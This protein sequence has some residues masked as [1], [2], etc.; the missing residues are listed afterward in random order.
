MYFPLTTAS[1]LFWL[2]K[3]QVSFNFA[4]MARIRGPFTPVDLSTALHRAAERHPLA[5][6]R[7]EIDAAGQGWLTTR[8]VA[9]IDLRIANCDWEHVVE[10]EL[11]RPFDPCAGPQ[12]RA[13]WVGGNASDAAAIDLILVFNHNVCDG[14]SGAFF[15]RDVL[16]LLGDPDAVLEPLNTYEGDLVNLIPRHVAAG[17]G[18]RLQLWAINTLA[19]LAW[20]VQKRFPRPT[21]PEGGPR[22]CVQAWT[23]TS[24]HTAALVERCRT[25]RTSVHAAVSAAWLRADA[26]IEEDLH[27]RSRWGSHWQRTVS[28]PVNL[29]R[30][31]SQPVGDSFGLFMSNHTTR[32]GCG[33]ERD[34]WEI[35]REIKRS[36]VHGLAGDRKFYWLLRTHAA[37]RGLSAAD[38]RGALALLSS[39]RPGYD[40]AISNLGRLDFPTQS[41][42]LHFEALYGPL[43][44]G[45]PFERTVSLLTFGGVMHFAF[46]FRDFVLDRPT[47]RRIQARAM[48]IL[49]QAVK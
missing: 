23:L 9:E 47:A 6:V 44:N 29:R 15:T 34:F 33:S 7:L 17:T 1:E 8:D 46:A 22:F 14:M 42:P 5:R 4:M 48:E 28:T 13:V 35:A 40:L 32:V 18:M 16:Q 19:P 39:Q 37:L 31:L 41:G 43:V 25:E 20:I 49:E 3:N 11:G 36:L 38:R 30:C 10:V 12:V 2:G 21:Q 26:E 24:D 27:P 45:F